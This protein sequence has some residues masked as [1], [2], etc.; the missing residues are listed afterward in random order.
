VARAVSS[1]NAFAVATFSTYNSYQMKHF[2]TEVGGENYT[3]APTRV[4]TALQRYIYS[5][6]DI[7]MHK[8]DIQTSTDMRADGQSDRVAAALHNVAGWRNE[9]KLIIHSVKILFIGNIGGSVSTTN[10]RS[11]CARCLVLTPSY[12]TMPSSRVYG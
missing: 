9:A 4:K 6:L 7:I 2:V 11:L 5:R 3:I 12:Q 10:D 1:C 8:Y